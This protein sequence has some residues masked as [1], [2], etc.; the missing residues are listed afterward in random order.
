M[1]GAMLA[2][3]SHPAK[4]PPVGPNWIYEIKHDGFRILARKDANGA[5]LFT[6]NG[7]DFADR[8]PRIVEAVVVGCQRLLVCNTT[9][10]PN[11]CP[12]DSQPAL[13]ALFVPYSV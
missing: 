3:Y 5:R 13:A 6:R 1:K 7:Y 4:E 11:F 8:F 12:T 10:R 9:H 2:P